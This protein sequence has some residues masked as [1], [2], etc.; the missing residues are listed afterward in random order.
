[1]PNMLIPSP[2]FHHMSGGKGDRPE[3]RMAQPNR[4]ELCGNPFVSP[5]HVRKIWGGGPI[6]NS[7]WP[8]LGMLL[9]EDGNYIHM[10]CGVALICSKWVITSGDC[11][12]E[13]KSGAKFDHSVKFGNLRWDKD[14]D[15]EQTVNVDKIIVHPHFDGGYHSDIALLRLKK[16]VSFSEY[17]RPICLRN[18]VNTGPMNCFAAGWGKTRTADSTKGAHQTAITLISQQTCSTV[19]G[20]KYDEDEMIC[21]GG[22]NRPCQGDGGAPLI[23]EAPLTGEWFLHGISIYGPGCSKRN[24]NG[25]SV[26][27]RPGAFIQFIR[28]VTGDCTAMYEE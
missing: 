9:E 7:Q 14:N 4:P 19:Y 17:V 22:V 13:L 10:K 20:N 28:D 3:L 6:S 27:V 21:T 18:F 1:V 11:A 16:S 15:D 26:F 12:H 23:C 8:W 2:E 25:P 5:A 24:N